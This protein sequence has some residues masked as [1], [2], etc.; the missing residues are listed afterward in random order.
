MTAGINASLSLYSRASKTDLSKTSALFLKCQKHIAIYFFS[1]RIKSSSY[2]QCGG[3]STF[4]QVYFHCHW[5]VRIFAEASS[6]DTS[7]WEL[8]II[9]SVISATASRSPSPSF[10][11]EGLHIQPDFWFESTFTVM[12]LSLLIILRNI[13]VSFS[14]RSL[15]LQF[16]KMCLCLIAQN[17]TSFDL[18]NFKF[19]VNAPYVSPAINWVP[20]LLKVTHICY[21]Q[22]HL[23]KLGLCL[24]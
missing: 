21:L 9:L 17:I 13:S 22:S 7:V 2:K 20:L 5:T 23:L 10:L 18:H 6:L 14:A 12:L 1:S 3:C 11:L 4:W 19:N 15:P 8:F 24:K 16:C